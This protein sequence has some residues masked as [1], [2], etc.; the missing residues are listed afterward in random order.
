MHISSPRYH[1]EAALKKILSDWTQ[2]R[3]S[4]QVHIDF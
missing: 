1:V 3:I 4:L 2:I